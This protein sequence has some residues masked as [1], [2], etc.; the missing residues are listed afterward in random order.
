MKVSR[1]PRSRAGFMIFDFLFLVLIIA[2]LALLLIPAL[3]AAREN[4]RRTACVHNLDQMGMALMSYA[5]DYGG[6][7]PC[8]PSLIKWDNGYCLDAQGRPTKSADHPCR[9]KEHAGDAPADSYYR[10]PS[11]HLFEYRWRADDEPVRLTDA[12]EMVRFMPHYWRTIAC[13]A[14]VQPDEERDAARPPLRHAPNG[15]GML[16]TGGY[17]ADA[18]AFYCPSAEANGMVGASDFHRKENAGK[19]FGYGGIHV[20][21]WQAAGGFDAEA[22]LYGDWGKPEA[23]W[24]HDA[25]ASMVQSSYAYRNV[26]QGGTAPMHWYDH[27]PKTRGVVGTEPPVAAQIGQA[28]FGTDRRLNG[29]ALVVDAFGKGM[30]HDARGR[31]Y[32][33]NGEPYE[34]AEA[35]REYA[36]VG[37]QAHRDAYNILYGDGSVRLYGDR[38]REIAFHLQAYATGD[39]PADQYFANWVAGGDYGNLCVNYFNM[40]AGAVPVIEN[41]GGNDPKHLKFQGTGWQVWHRF[42]NTAGIDLF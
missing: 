4:A 35:S 28:P 6:Y 17:L 20:A 25:D 38:K 42:D 27:D 1:T 21:H 2:I 15:L 13:G 34:D 33:K 5:G 29:R 3:L 10:T 8:S 11:A 14:N 7:Y 40:S 31:E 18:R 12:G 32:P 37:I 36:G 19:R 9:W 41:C 16:M 26:M 24:W 39:T 30:R 22:L 23:G